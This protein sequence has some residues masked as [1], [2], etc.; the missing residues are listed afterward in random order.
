VKVRVNGEET[1]LERESTIDALVERLGLGGKRVAVELNRSVVRRENWP[2]TVIVE[3]DH[4]E[5]VQFVGG[6]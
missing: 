2:T 6:G 4:V 3:N 1:E 5:I